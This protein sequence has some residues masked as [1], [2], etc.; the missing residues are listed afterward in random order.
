MKRAQRLRKGTE[1]D[2]A[3]S[4]GTAVGGPL[5]VVRVCPNGLGVTRWG[6]AVGK[7]LAPH[8]VV[9]NRT[10]RVIREAARGLAVQQGYDIIVVARQPALAAS[11]QDLRTAITRGL[12][13][14]GVE[15]A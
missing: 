10:K 1:F 6:F 15:T 14:A 5:L 11:L 9:R 13:K 2:T 7:K 3:F 4:K 12:A 8:A